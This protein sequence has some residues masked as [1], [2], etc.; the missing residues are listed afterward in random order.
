MP[1][2]SQEAQLRRRNE[3]ATAAFERVIQREDPVATLIAQV[4]WQQLNLT[5]GECADDSGLSARALAVLE[6][7]DKASQPE[8]FDRLLEYWNTKTVAVA[9]QEQLRRL[10]AGKYS[11]ME[12]F[13]EY[14]CYRVGHARF[15]E[16]LPADGEFKGMTQVRRVQR[17]RL[18]IIP[19]YR[20]PE[21]IVARLY[22]TDDDLPPD[23]RVALLG[24]ADVTWVAEKKAQLLG[25]NIEPVLV[26]FLVALERRCGKAGKSYSIEA[27]MDWMTYEMAHAFS[28]C[29]MWPW[30]DQIRVL[31][32]D[33]G[34]ATEDTMAD[35]E[36]A[37]TL[38]AS[39]EQP[40]DRFGRLFRTVRDAQGITNTQLAAWVGVEDKRRGDGGERKSSAATE[41]TAPVRYV[42]DTA[43][44]SEHAPASV[45][46]G[47]VA[48]NGE[49]IGDQSEADALADTFRQAR[50]DHYS[51]TGSEIWSQGRNAQGVRLRAERD[52]AGLSA[53][54]VAWQMV[55]HAGEH[56]RLQAR[57]AELEAAAPVVS[58]KAGR[59][60]E[61]ADLRRQL[62][63][64]TH[65]MRGR[66][67]RLL[68][69]EAGDVAMTEGVSAPRT[70]GSGA[71]TRQPKCIKRGELTRI[72]NAIQS[73]AAARLTAAQ[74][75][76]A[77]ERNVPLA[78]AE[79]TSV[80]DGVQKLA[81]HFGGFTSLEAVVR[82][83]NGTAA[84]ERDRLAFT[85]ERAQGIVAGTTF[86]PLPLLA[87]MLEAVEKSSNWKLRTQSAAMEAHWYPDYAA[88]LDGRAANPV[89]HP[90]P[91]ALEVI[92]AA[93][94]LSQEEFAT[95]LPYD[96]S[97]LSQL[98]VHLR[99]GG[100]SKWTSVAP[101][102]KAGGFTDKHPFSMLVQRMLNGEV[103]HEVLCAMLPHMDRHYGRKVEA[104]DLP[105]FTVAEVEAAR[106]VV[107]VAVELEKQTTVGVNA[108]P[109][110][111]EDT[112]AEWFRLEEVGMLAAFNRFRCIVTLAVQRAWKPTSTKKEMVAAA[113]GEI[114]RLQSKYSSASS[115][116]DE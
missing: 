28:G 45:L 66:R 69:I 105:G 67:D 8:T 111:D 44:A 42:I 110:P 93:N 27:M 87:N 76:R 115:G 91:R 25:R 40:R 78:L 85:A 77:A 38:A 29:R 72:D 7:P 3:N 80:A 15:Y 112:I 19:D 113:M 43:C 47:L 65:A 10:L 4:R 116:S 9:T 41:V 1:A 54:D 74:Q 79:F 12:Q 68:D 30:R 20:E 32:L 37:W 99:G 84:K 56:V 46:I 14:L 31:A 57:I 86:A 95:H 59:N 100:K 35:F 75:R 55:D 81:D 26:D 11:G 108:I 94:A 21:Q 50:I 49:K 64:L 16:L 61:L 52:L 6:N 106:K 36:A 82:T 63:A 34:L 60:P 62:T 73:A 89:K 98:L 17:R 5:Y 39:V 97:N 24:E 22:P 103:P 101:V 53:E 109:K 71:G 90:L 23:E 58:G 88:H 70:G 114:S 102:L 107:G 83:S 48:R 51:R 13:Y 92:V 96:S 33:M 104:Q 18:G 2:M